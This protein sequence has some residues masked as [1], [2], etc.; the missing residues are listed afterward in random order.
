MLDLIKIGVF[1]AAIAGAAYAVNRAWTGFKD[2]IGRPYA[3]AQRSA[4][5]P[6]IDKANKAQSAAEGER[7]HAQQDTA[8][9]VAS[10]AKQSDAVHQ[11]Q[12]QA[13]LN[14]KRAAAAERA[15]RETSDSRAIEIHR[16]QAEAARHETNAQTCEQRLGDLD[17]VLRD[18]AR[19]R[20]AT[21]R[22]LGL[23]E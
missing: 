9:C 11:W 4:D 18:D 22:V 1:L 5:Q 20:A 8:A 16:Y 13:E 2:D 14:A 7:D 17:K 19:A 6:V 15:G 21:K 12:A 23:A 10:A 3:A